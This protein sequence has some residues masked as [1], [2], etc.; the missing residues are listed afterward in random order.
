MTIGKIVN[1]RYLGTIG[2]IKDT[3]KEKNENVKKIK[4][5]RQDVSFWIWKN[6][7]FRKVRIIG[8]NY[9]TW[10]VQALLLFG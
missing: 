10:E 2:N 8:E 3:G 6:K 1:P 9:C 7:K 4:K 5:M